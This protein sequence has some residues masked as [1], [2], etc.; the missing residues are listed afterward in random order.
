MTEDRRRTLLV[1]V[2]LAALTAVAYEGVRNNDFV[3]YD[4]D[5]YVTDNPQ[6]QK[7]LCPESI[8][9]AFTTFESGNWHPLTWLSHIIDCSIFGLKPAG[10]HLVNVGF[11]IINVLLLF[12]ILKRMAG[13]LWP[14]AF[15]AAVFGLHPLMVES[16]AWV[17]ERKNVLSTFFA[18]LTIA[19]YFRWTQK[20]GFW[21]Y[22]A[23]AVLFAAGL[24]SKPM[25]VT[26]PFALILLD[27]WPLNRLNSK[28]SILNSLYEKL[29]MMAMSAA[30]CVVTYAAQAKS[31]AITDFVA[32]PLT[33][34]L[35]NALLSYV[36]YLGKIFYPSPLAVLYPFNMNGPALWQTVACL[37]LLVLVSSAALVLRRR[38]G[39]LFTGWFWYLGTLV[40]V[41]GLIQVG[42]QSMA[43]RY[44][45]WPGIGIYI[46]VA[47]LACDLGVKLKL[48]KP[49]LATAGAVVLGV[50]MTLTWLQVRCWKNSMSLYERTLAVTKNNYR[51]ETNYGELLRK[52]GRLDEAI[53]HFKAAIAADPGLARAHHNLGIV[54]GEKGNFAEATA[55]FE[56]ALELEPNSTPAHNYY[57][58]CLAQQGLYDK[59]IVHFSRALEPGKHFS[60]VLQN[61]CNAGI[62]AGKPDIA[63]DVIK[64]WQLKTPDNA[65]LYY[66]AAI[67]YRQKGDNA[68]ATEQLD[69][70]MKLAGSQGNKELIARIK[71]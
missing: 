49:V 33:L 45:Y 41:I 27:Y 52:A 36:R 63:L 54:Y 37:L 31:M 24:L 62:M 22:L 30:S 47:W 28:F 50:L 44:M 35:E 4:D 51:I 65:E 23:V 32:L 40:P 55:E 46:I 48:P 15:A 34:R 56:Q 29:P 64:E 43:D 12:L 18:L 8:K 17:A 19:A 60:G 70:A 71:R 39:Y 66:Q 2:I 38:C 58:I 20:Q 25:L 59:A 69:K 5:S 14:S 42:L 7:G 3:N 16:V 26:L 61:L 53:P 9:W 13:A 57:A 6:V 1:C 11:H 68:R 10:H 21:R 67:I